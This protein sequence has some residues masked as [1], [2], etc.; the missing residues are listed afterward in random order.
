[1]AES[2]WQGILRILRDGRRHTAASIGDALGCQHNTV[3]RYIHDLRHGE[4]VVGTVDIQDS[5]VDGKPYKEYW[6]AG[7]ED[8]YRSWRDTLASYP[9]G[10]VEKVK[11]EAM[12]GA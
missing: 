5:P 4:T 9:A 6:L 2:V 8:P 12:M 3:Q 10:H 7:K 11:Y 1:M